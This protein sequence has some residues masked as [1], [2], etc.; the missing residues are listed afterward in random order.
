MASPEVCRLDPLEGHFVPSMQEV[1]D[2]ETGRSCPRSPSLALLPACTMPS[3]LPTHVDGGMSLH[4]LLP[5]LSAWPRV[6]PA[7]PR[8]H[9]ESQAPVG[10]GRESA[11][12][13]LG[14]MP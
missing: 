9:L 12:V 11:L 3:W 10:W 13:P 5:R 7:G 1:P 4:G 2:G 6:L 14:V 8:P